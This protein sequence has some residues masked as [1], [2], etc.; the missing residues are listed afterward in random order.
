[1][2][3]EEG[4]SHPK[5]RARATGRKPH[6][7]ATLLL[8]LR[9]PSHERFGTLRVAAQVRARLP[10]AGLPRALVRHAHHAAQELGFSVVPDE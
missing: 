7:R 3:R 10:G 8:R 5:R 6:V 1:M 9:F 2:A 4:G